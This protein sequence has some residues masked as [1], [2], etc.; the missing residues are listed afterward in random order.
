M[1]R[2]R[3]FEPLPG[4][5]Q[6]MRSLVLRHV[7]QSMLARPYE[8][9]LAGICMLVGAPLLGGAPNPDSIDALL[10]MFL[11][12]VW[13]FELITGAVLVTVGLLIYPRTH[14]ERLGHSLLAPAAITYGIA[15]IAVVGWGG[16]LAGGLTIGF[17]LAA[18]TRSWV[19]R[20]AERLI[21]EAAR[22]G[23]RDE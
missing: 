17:G 3:P 1:T 4:W 16:V 19:L 14:L 7:P 10:P 5:R 2:P 21:E 12:R 11:V 20:L 15:I 23:F 6:R 9:Y 13:G 8:L 18:G 22:G